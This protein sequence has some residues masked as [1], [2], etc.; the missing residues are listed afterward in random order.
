MTDA[1]WSV[2]LKIFTIWQSNLSLHTKPL[3]TTDLLSLTMV[4]SVLE[5]HVNIIILCVVFYAGF[6]LG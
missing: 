5:I 3:G 6:L 4:L 1:V 2:R